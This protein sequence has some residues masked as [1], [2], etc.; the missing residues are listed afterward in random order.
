MSWKSTRTMFLNK[1]GFDK[2]CKSSCETGKDKGR[3]MSTGFSN[4][5]QHNIIYYCSTTGI[6]RADRVKE[7]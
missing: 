4:K 3:K 2:N 1:E 7:A 6:E 5:K